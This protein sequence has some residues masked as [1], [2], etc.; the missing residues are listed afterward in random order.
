[1]WESETSHMSAV[2]EILNPRLGRPLSGPQ[3]SQDDY[4]T[5]FSGTLI[6]QMTL[7]N[8]R[9]NPRW[10]VLTAALL[11][12]QILAVVTLCLSVNTCS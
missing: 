2:A 1:M 8:E 11:K 7:R 3:F 4:T 12:T 10:E 6:G 9:N 5:A